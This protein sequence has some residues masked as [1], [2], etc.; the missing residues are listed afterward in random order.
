[1]IAEMDATVLEVQSIHNQATQEGDVLKAICVSDKLT[2]LQKLQASTTQAAKGIANPATRLK[3]SGDLD[4]SRKESAQLHKEA[5]ACMGEERA[6]D[7]DELERGVHE[8]DDAKSRP[9]F[10]G[11]IDGTE[12]PYLGLPPDPFISLPPVVS[13]GTR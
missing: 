12:G 9:E 13:S 10:D 1:L 3:A 11:A 2:Q 6:E 8:V 4:K 5:W 7:V